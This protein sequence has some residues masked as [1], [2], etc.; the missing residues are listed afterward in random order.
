MCA[1]LIFVVIASVMRIITPQQTGTVLGFAIL[2][3]SFNLCVDI[4]M[5]RKQI[6]VS[7]QVDSSFSD[8]NIALLRKNITFNIATWL[9]L[10]LSFALRKFEWAMYIEPIVCILVSIYVFVRNLK[11][12][13]RA[14]TDLLD[15]TVDEENQLEILKAVAPIFGDIKTFYEVRSRCSGTDVFVDLLVDFEDDDTYEKIKGVYNVFSDLVKEKYPNYI[16]S[17]V[18][19]KIEEE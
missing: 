7:K 14:M 19:T 6:K 8:G 13:G 5:L 4:Y 3:K 1:G 15:K 10:C 12:I 16:P 17:L 9:T 11:V 2:L 18:I